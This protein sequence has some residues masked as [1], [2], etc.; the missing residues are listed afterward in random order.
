MT[1]RIILATVLTGQTLSVMAA[2][3]AQLETTAAPASAPVSAERYHVRLRVKGEDRWQA[4]PVYAFFHQ[5]DYNSPA[6]MGTMP[7]VREVTYRDTRIESCEDDY[8]FDIRPNRNSPGAGIENIRIENV[9]IID[10]PFRPSRIVALT[11]H[12]IRN[13]TIRGLM[14]LGQW[15]TNAQ[16]GRFTIENAAY[17]LQ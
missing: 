14:I 17:D 10:S 8:F 3:P 13:V 11:N 1:P 15:I 4:A 12:P 16:Q 5:H 2:T 9:L 6:Y 7:P